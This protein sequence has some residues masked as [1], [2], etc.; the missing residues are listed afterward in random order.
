MPRI[1]VVVPV[2]NVERYLAECL[3]SLRAQTVRDYEVVM[4]EDGST[5][6][7]AAIAEE[8]AER[9]PRFRLVVQEN[10]GLGHARN[11]GVRHAGGELLAFVDSDDVVTPD[12]YER[13][14]DSLDT[15]GS[16]FASGNVLRLDEDGRTKQA[17]FLAQTFARTRTKT[18]VR[19]FAPLLADRTAWNKLWRR[20]FWDANALRFPEGVRYE[21][22]P[23]TL[24]AHVMARS[25][26]VIAEP[27]YHWRIRG[28]GE[29]SITQKRLEMRSLVDRL[30][31]IEHVRAYL[32]EH[33]TRRLRRRYDERLVRD[34][35]RVHLD[36]LAD[37]D[38]RYRTLF[39]DHV[40]EMFD[41]A[42]PSLFAAL[43]AIDRLKWHLA[44]HGQT[45]ELLEVLRFTRERKEATA[46]LRRRGRW[47]GDY[48]FRD[49][50]AVGIPA[51]TFRLGKRDA[52]LA[53]RASV[54]ELVCEDGR[55]VVRGH[56]HL[57]GFGVER[58][59][60]Q[61]VQLIAVR[62]GRLL[63]LRMRLGAVRVRARAV[64]RPDLAG[65]PFDRTWSGFEATLPP[66][67]LRKAGTWQLVLFVRAHG[68]RRRYL[69]FAH[70]QLRAA[71]LPAPE[72]L[73]ARA[74][75]C[76]SGRIEVRVRDRWAAIQDAR[77]V[78]GDVLELIGKQ[79][80]GPVSEIEVRRAGD[81]WCTRIPLAGEVAFSAQLPLSQLHLAP[82][83]RGGES[84]IWQLSALDGERRVPLALPAASPALIHCRSG[85]ELTL[86]RTPA[87][88]AALTDRDA[89]PT[90]TAARWRVG[91][92]LELELEMP[93]GLAE[94]QLV[95]RDWHRE[96]T[97][98]V[99]ML[100]AGDD[101]WRVLIPAAALLSVPAG[102][103]PRRG[104]WRFYGRPA[105]SEELTALARVR[106]AQEAAAA[107]PLTS[108]VDD[109]RFDLQ[110]APDGSL[111]LSVPARI[112]APAPA[113]GERGRARRGASSRA[114]AE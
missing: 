57:A 89:R 11:T 83:D 109:R 64:R 56:A 65:G 59:A 27:V 94:R 97:H 41:G 99:P 95:L 22:T 88:D 74:V 10:G 2:Y 28:A 46:P 110:P 17:A 38:P 51:S 71:E 84:A 29:R 50:R 26:D 31:A 15:S 76:T 4:V 21:D 33:G 92:V 25:V 104:E 98:A 53:L 68:L 42:R 86:A 20:E 111:L 35:L 80:L 70:E 34:D 60:D 108:T 14:A 90:V 77:L 100:P 47:Y 67:A 101:H 19:H 66:S 36:V 48:P 62:R 52:E 75:A 55:L 63:R 3:R 103:T 112:A 9:D 12:A 18:H 49:D 114:P 45:A 85:R 6:G 61:R 105:G 91:D 78:D 54:D 79:R 7:S 93:A 37:A 40:M 106:L 96:R 44:L 1:S 81:G 23:V 82:R 73:A 24:P 30:A 43:P 8:F 58:P 102:P 113:R 69:R 39:L 13:L 72:G 32:A 107:L 87:G 5:D 16:D